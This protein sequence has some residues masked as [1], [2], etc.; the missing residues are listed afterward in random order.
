[1]ADDVP[2]LRP[3]LLPPLGALVASLGLAAVAAGAVLGALAIRDWRDQRRIEVAQRTTA[4]SRAVAD[5]IIALFGALRRAEVAGAESTSC[6][7]SVT[8]KI[9]MIE[10]PVLDWLVDDGGD[11][12]QPRPALAVRSP[13]FHYLDGSRA[14][15][16][17]DAVAL[18]SRRAALAALRSARYLAV[19]SGEVT[20]ATENADAMLL[21]GG[22]VDATVA[23]GE[24]T[25]GRFVCA[26]RFTS[27]PAVAT[28]LR[29]S[30]R[31]A[32]HAAERQATRETMARGFQAEAR[33]QLAMVAPGA[34]LD[35]E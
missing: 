27:Q 30:R 34:M 33:E 7:P 14:P 9:P 29:P 12:E 26:F 15:G 8:G 24:I 17:D 16:L 2:S 11:E 28:W 22:E 32:D 4:H 25:G 6:P 5:Q 19:V 3:S 13:V 10:K 23:I 20:D 21:D 18:E 35:V 1:M 31:R